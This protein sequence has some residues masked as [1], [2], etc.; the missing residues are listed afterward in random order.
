VE[1]VLECSGLLSGVAVGDTVKVLVR[2]GRVIGLSDLTEGEA[3]LV[4]SAVA[5]PAI[6]SRACL[7]CM[8]VSMAW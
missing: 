8:T 6:N 2:A 3:Q 7:N 4:K 5:A 1:S